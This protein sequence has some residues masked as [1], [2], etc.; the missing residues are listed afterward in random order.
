MILIRICQGHWQPEIDSACNIVDNKCSVKYRR[1]VVT[2]EKE[3][4]G[5]DCEHEDGDYKLEYCISDDSLRCGEGECPC[6]PETQEGCF[7]SAGNILASHQCR[8]TSGNHMYQ[9]ECISNTCTCDNGTAATGSDCNPNG[10]EM[11]TDCNSGY[12]LSGGQCLATSC[13]CPN[14]TPRNGECLRR[15]GESTINCDS[16]NLGYVIGD[17]PDDQLFSTIYN[18]VPGT[19]EC[20]NPKDVNL[21]SLDLTNLNIERINSGECV[22]GNSNY[23]N[24]INNF[25][26]IPGTFNTEDG[27]FRNTTLTLDYSNFTE[28]DDGTLS[29]NQPSLE[30]KCILNLVYPLLI[31]G[32]VIQYIVM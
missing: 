20:C 2:R 29:F 17:C 4:N 1:Y 5:N 30:N 15:D 25:R 28:N 12:S 27:I 32:H 3:G 7:T 31:L 19:G 21:D 6:N 8:C 24:C 18:N 14:G 23:E 9:H 16:C 13:I 10:S 26:C 11:C 22:Q